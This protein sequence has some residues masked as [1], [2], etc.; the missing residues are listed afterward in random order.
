MKD[1]VYNGQKYNLNNLEDYIKKDYWDAD[2]L[3]FDFWYRMHIHNMI[4]NEVLE[5]NG[6]KSNT[7]DI[8]NSDRLKK[9]IID[10]NKDYKPMKL[11]FNFDN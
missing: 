5:L 7:I 4:I 1:Y 11:T 10:K 6:I 9:E 3:K 8:D 2:D